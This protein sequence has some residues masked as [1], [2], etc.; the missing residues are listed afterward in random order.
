[1]ST[2]DG[3]VV[4]PGG[5]PQVGVFGGGVRLDRQHVQQRLRDLTQGHRIRTNSWPTMV[6]PEGANAFWPS[7]PIIM[8]A[9]LAPRPLKDR[10]RDL[11][12]VGDVPKGPRTSPNS[13]LA[14]AAQGFGISQRVWPPKT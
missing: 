2:H 13:V 4:R 1:M 12:S 8:V 5:L 14:K 10:R 7:W 6:A 3:G 11:D 9:T